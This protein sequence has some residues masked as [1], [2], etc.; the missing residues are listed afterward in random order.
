MK[1]K[2]SGITIIYAISVLLAAVLLTWLGI[3]EQPDIY[4]ERGEYGYR[5]ITGYQVESRSDVH[6]PVG[7]VREYSWT[8]EDVRRQDTCI[9]FYVVHQYVDVYFDDE[10]MYHLGPG[11]TQKLLR[12]LEATGLLFPF[13]RKIREGKC[14]WWYNRYIRIL[15]TGRLI[16]SLVSGYLSLWTG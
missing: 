1:K 5:E 16:F 13:F 7:V 10:L 14:G 11:R 6:A 9:A 3:K 4:Q 8:F 12:P 15:L 2:V